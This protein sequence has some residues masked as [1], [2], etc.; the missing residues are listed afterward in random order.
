MSVRA[1]SS[2]SPLEWRGVVQHQPAHALRQQGR[3]Q[4]LLVLQAMAGVGD[5]Q[6]QA[7]GARH[8]GNGVDHGRIERVADRRDHQ[9]DD[10]G[11]LGRQAAGD[12]VGQVAE[13]AH[14]GVDLAAHLVRH[15]RGIAERA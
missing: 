10:V 8:V 1:N 9:A 14:R 11:A 7:V 6:M 2:R 4:R 5:H 13:L 3:D 12:A 15:A